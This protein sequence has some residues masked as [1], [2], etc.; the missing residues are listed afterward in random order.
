MAA[1]YQANGT[2]HVR[3]GGSK[4]VVTFTPDQYFEQG[5]RKFIVFAPP[6]PPS[7]T[8]CKLVAKAWPRDGAK[9]VKFRVKKGKFK[10]SILVAATKAIKVT[11]L[12]SKRT[13]GKLK[14]KRVI[15][16]AI[17]ISPVP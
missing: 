8:S 16:P 3:F 5:G 12:V 2:I 9:G 17:P 15:I 11:V 14:L 6:R 13:D 10:T 1:T 7:N 4:Y